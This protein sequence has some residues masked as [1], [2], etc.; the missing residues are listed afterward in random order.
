MNVQTDAQDKSLFEKLIQNN[1]FVGAYEL[2][3]D[4][5][6][7]DIA[8]RLEELE[9]EQAQQLLDQ[10]SSL[11]SAEVLVEL[12]EEFRQLLLKEYSAEEIAEEVIENLDSDDAADII[13]ELPESRKREVLSQ[14]EDIEQ[15]KQIAD[16]LTHAEDTAGALMAT[17]LIKVNQNW[18]VWRCVKEMRRQAEEIEQVHAVYVVDDNDILLGTLSLKKLLT[19]STKTPVK[20]LFNPK[21]ISVKTSQNDEEVGRI[22]QKYD[23]V[24][25]PVV[26]ELGRLCG[27]ITIDDIVD[28]IQEEAEKDYQ[29]A[30]GLTADVEDSDSVMKLSKARLPWILIGMIGGIMSS[31]VIDYFGI[32][33]NPEMALF[34]TLIAATGGNVGVQSAALVVQS[35]ARG[36]QGANIKERLLKDLSVGLFTSL[37]CSLLMFVLSYAL[38]QNLQLSL[39]VALSLIAVIIFAA[40]MG[41]FVP[42]VL[43]RLNI[44]P[45]VATG[46]FITTTND[47][48][49]LFIYFTIGGLIFAA[50]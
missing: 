40:G 20:D 13:S 39:T 28:V 41:T 27:R 37:A 32:T 9:L 7:P 35:L 11:D 4:L 15:A 26:D 36:S 49:G 34:I 14:I 50:A 17:E 46:P 44:D 3:K 2:I 5:H 42:L 24:V 16:L 1:D 21:V 30:S 8:E 22:M 18:N 43:N 45:A 19:T 48:L 25:V 12:D 47:V 29:L 38:Y 33:E 10:F 31:K 23:L 6:A